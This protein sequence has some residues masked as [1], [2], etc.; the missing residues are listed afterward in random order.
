MTRLTSRTTV[1]IAMGFIGGALLLSCFAATPMTRPG[2]SNDLSHV[3]RFELG[4]TYLQ[5]GDSIT[6]NEVRGTS[7]ALTAGNMYQ[8]KGTY[9]LASRDKALLA[10]FVTTSG[11]QTDTPTPI[12][13]TQKMTVDRGEGHFT[14]LFYMWQDGSPHV[15][16]Y[17]VPSGD[18]FAG[19]YFGTK[20]SVF[21]SPRGTLTDRV[22]DIH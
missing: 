10:T 21:K 7:D 1:L 16:L 6:I 15:S 12:M 14:L 3:V 19:V 2:T 13:R 4:T 22:T 17:P 5:H 20:N 8:V 11:R 18:S 9:K